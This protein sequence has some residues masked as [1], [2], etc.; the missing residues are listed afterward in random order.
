MWLLFRTSFVCVWPLNCLSL[1]SANTAE[2]ADT[3]MDGRTKAV[4]PRSSSTAMALQAQAKV[5]SP[6]DLGHPGRT[7]EE[8][9]FFLSFSLYQQWILSGI[10]RFPKHTGTGNYP[11]GLIMLVMLWCH[12]TWSWWVKESGFGPAFVLQRKKGDWVV[13]SFRCRLTRS[14]AALKMW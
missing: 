7:L 9:F 1:L 4:P 5:P 12:G 11:H 14:I 10:L 2:V 3:Q 13:L 8:V 6:P